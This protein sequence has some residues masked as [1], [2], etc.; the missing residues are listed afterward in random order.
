[1]K[2]LMLGLTLLS[3]LLLSGCQNTGRGLQ[4]DTDQNVDA[5]RRSINS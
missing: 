4:Q 5:F 3:V 1:M 2:M